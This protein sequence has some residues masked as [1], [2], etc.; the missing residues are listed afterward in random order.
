MSASG[1]KA[2]IEVE[3]W[4]DLACPW[5]YVGQKRIDKAVAELGDKAEVEITWHAFLLDPSYHVNH[6]EG[7]PLEPF[8]QAKFGKNIDAIKERLLA[9]GRPDGALF[10]NWNFRPNT[11]SG[12][13]LVA[14]AR[15][16]GNSHEANKALFRKSY[17]E[18]K[19]IS[20]PEVLEEVS[21]ELQLPRP[22]EWINTDL[23][24]LEVMKDD[25]EAKQRSVNLFK[26]GSL[27]GWRVKSWAEP[28]EVL[29]A[30]PFPSNP[31]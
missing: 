1:P 24:V 13:R 11:V 12:H 31:K 28:C 5:C 17:E 4:S 3:V 23:G 16:N 18:G 21:E 29:I 20:L 14:L 6:P 25:D 22:S 10:S 27:L 30:R 15:R 8:Y 2:K 9:S 26:I 7:E 19:N